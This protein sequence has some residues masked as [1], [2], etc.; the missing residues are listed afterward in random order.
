MN[1]DSLCAVAVVGFERLNYSI[2]E[3][4]VRQDICVH[5]SNPSQNE[6]LVYDIFLRYES[7]MDSASKFRLKSEVFHGM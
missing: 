3:T 1:T 4:A 7:K 5:V 2:V 6:A